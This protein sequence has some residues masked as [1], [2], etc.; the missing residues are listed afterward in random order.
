MFSVKVHHEGSFDLIAICDHE[1]LGKSLSSSSSCVQVTT[2][3]YG[4]TPHDTAAI[5]SLF[6]HSASFNLLGNAIVQLAVDEGLVSE[7]DVT[8]IAG[9]SHAQLYH[10]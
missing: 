3:F 2:S 10:V 4:N 8:T 6:H 5:I 7:K 1:L 9:I